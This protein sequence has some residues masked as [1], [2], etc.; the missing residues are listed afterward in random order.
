MARTWRVA[1]IGLGHWYSA[2]GLARAMPE[3][4]RAE[5]V[6]AAWDDKVQLEAFTTS[7]GVRGYADYREMLEREEVDIVHLASPVARIP[8]ITIHCAGAGKHLVLGKP[9]A[10]SVAEADRMVEAVESAGVVCMPFQGIMRLRGKE[11][12]SRV[13]AGEIGNIIL[14]HQTS[15]WSI[16]EDWYSSGK[17][18]WFADPSQ[19]PGGAFI[20]EGIYWIDFFRWLA[21]SEV[22]RVEAKTANL[23]HKDIAVE[24]WG[25][26]TFTFAN[27]IIATLEAAW[28]INAPRKSG[29]SPKQN[30][31]VRMEIVGS[32][33]EIIDQ[34]FRSPGR[35]V[36][37]AGASDWIFERQSEAPPFAPPAPFP[38]GHLIDCLDNDTKPIATIRDARSSFVVAMAAYESARKGLAIQLAS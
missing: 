23:V 22:T 4:S 10:M 9:M 13:D 8:E 34:W 37:T 12:K 28:T 1:V 18:G 20:D 38:L 36:L 21:S 11:L 2:Y 5:L 6:A 27:G 31:V 15:R 3:Y 7:F 29:P 24:D 17:P 14:L 16:A 25:M 33:G 32:R 26:A 35:A 19:V 30:A